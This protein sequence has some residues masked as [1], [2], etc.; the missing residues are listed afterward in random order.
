VRIGA[1]LRCGRYRIALDRPRVMGI[2]NVTPDSFSD[3]GYWAEPSRAIEHGLQL[4]EQGADLLDIGAESTRPGSASVSVSEELARLLPVIEGL[5]HCGVALSID[6]RKPEVMREVLAAGIDMINDIEGF[7]SPAS[8]R[9]VAG[10]EAGLC[11]MHMQGIPATM[12]QAPAY[13]DVV[14]QVSAFLSDR[15]RALLDAGVSA[16]QIILDPGIGFG[17]SCAHN[18][19]L[20]QHLAQIGDGRFAL[21]VGLSRKSM[22]GELTGRAVSERLA[23]SLA[24]AI[25]AVAGGAAIVRVHDVVQTVDALKVWHAIREGVPHA[26]CAA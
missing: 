24:G 25:A 5:R 26:A 17:K 8:I 2:V 13:T 7:A 12:Q 9:A 19:A 14:A 18:I 3:G 16:D 1:E 15:S 21:L 6:T 11:V 22:I 23:G 20:L 4:V 10:S